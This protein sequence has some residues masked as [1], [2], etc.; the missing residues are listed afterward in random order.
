MEDNVGPEVEV[1]VLHFHVSRVTSTGRRLGGL[2]VACT[3][4]VSDELRFRRGGDVRGD[5]SA[6]DG[7]SKK[8]GGDR[9]GHPKTSEH[10]R[11]YTTECG[12]T[13][14]KSDT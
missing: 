9:E 10:G 5:H 7:A 6:C 11:G 8:G 4:G 1:H 12:P 2:G 3:G 14:A 13:H